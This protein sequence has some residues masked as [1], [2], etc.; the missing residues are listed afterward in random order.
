[1][2]V[3]LFGDR[4]LIIP[5]ALEEKTKGGLYIPDS[6]KDSQ[7]KVMATVYAHGIGF[8]DEN[9]GKLS[10]AKVRDGDRVSLSKEVA[11]SMPLG[12]DMTG[13]KETLYLINESDIDFIKR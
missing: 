5:D 4:V 7:N 13:V 1:M 11:F 10:P 12:E 3:T 6:V 9:T 2:P 8:M